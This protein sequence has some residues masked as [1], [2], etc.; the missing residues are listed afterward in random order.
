[1][2]TGMRKALIIL[3]V[4]AILAVGGL[5]W[6]RQRQND[7]PAETANTSRPFDASRYS[8]TDPASIWIVVNKLRPLEPSSYKP[9]D[10]RTPDVPLRTGKLAEDMK[11]RDAAAVALEKLFAAASGSGLKLMLASGYRSY[12]YQS[13]L[14]DTYVRTQ[15]QAVADTQSARAGYSEH[16][17]GWAAD[18][19]AVSRACEIEGCFAD[20]PEGTWV[21][22]NAYKYGFVIRYPESKQ[23][24]TG[25]I[26]EPWHL[27]Y[28]GKT[29][30][31]ELHK[32]G[33]PALEEFFGLPAAPDYP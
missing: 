8:T 30:A 4:A 22:A 26:Y 13:G 31:A 12:S 2:V 25:Y 27:R 32:Q 23:D 14:Y 6:D 24:I 17:T 28:V 20:T 1:M 21:A 3:I 29:L 11:L 33:N 7:S 18:I 16:Q 10:L 5:V 19:G 15:G 9:S